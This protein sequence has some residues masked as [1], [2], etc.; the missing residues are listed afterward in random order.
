MEISL[1]GKDK[2]QGQDCATYYSD[3][4]HMIQK[5]EKKITIY[6]IAWG[7]LSGPGLT[8]P[9]PGSVALPLQSDRNNSTYNIIVTRLQIHTIQFGPTISTRTYGTFACF[10]SCLT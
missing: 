6:N 5:K 3:M 2:F 8:V 7:L 1:S 9:L 4:G 10:D